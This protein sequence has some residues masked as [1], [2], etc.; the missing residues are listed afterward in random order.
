MAV[1]INPITIFC[2]K[3]LV[4]A[5]SGTQKQTGAK[6]GEFIGN[7]LLVEVTQVA[8]QLILH[9]V[10][11]VFGAASEKFKLTIRIFVFLANDKHSDL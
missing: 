7:V 8:Y 11:V 1:Q 6:N 2:D 4:K 5:R 9:S 3:K 10:G